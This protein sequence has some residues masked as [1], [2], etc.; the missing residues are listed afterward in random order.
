LLSQL[1]LWLSLAALW[2]SRRRSSPATNEDSRAFDIFAILGAAFGA[3]YLLH[4]RFSF[5]AFPFWSLAVVWLLRAR[6][7]TTG[8]QVAILGRRVPSALAA[9]VC[10]AA[11]VLTSRGHW[12]GLLE[13]TLGGPDGLALEDRAAM[14]ARIPDSA[15]VATTWGDADMLVYYQPRAQYLE[16]LDP[17]PMFLARPVEHA[18]KEA[19]FGGTALD[20]P[21][22]VSEALDSEYVVWSTLDAQETTLGRRLAGD[23]RVEL[24]HRG[25]RT[26]VRLRLDANQDFVLD[27]RVLPAAIPASAD[28]TGW[29]SYPRAASERARRIEGFVDLRRLAEPPV[30]QTLVHEF[31]T[32]DSAHSPYAISAVGP[33]TVWLDGDPVFQTPGGQGFLIDRSV[34]EGAASP[35]AHRW[36]VRSCPAPGNGAAGFYFISLP[37]N[38]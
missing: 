4:S 15:R 28:P 1:G 24:L 14:A 29:A 25:Q 37:R 5:F 38:G 32:A 33:T 30:C 36:T 3:L 7:E 8:G 9:L 34:L 17:L 31:R 11:M 26:L 13:R 21:L 23:P 12:A 22:T 27:W 16:I 20:A 19:V 10:A 18:A 6:G 35:G 2:L